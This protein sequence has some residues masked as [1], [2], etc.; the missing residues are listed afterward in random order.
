MK[1]IVLL[2]NEVMGPNEEA[3][4]LLSEELD[5]E[6]KGVVIVDENHKDDP[7]RRRS[8]LFHEVYVD[9]E[10]QS[11]IQLAIEPIKDKILLVTCRNEPNLTLL[12]KVIPNVPYI[13]TPTET[14]IAWSTSKYEM[15]KRFSISDPT[16]S[17]K[18]MNVAD[19]SSETVA[20]LSKDVGFPAIVKPAGLM[21][22]LLVQEVSD[23]KE[24]QRAL[25]DIFSY[26][27]GVH[28]KVG[29]HEKPEVVVEERLVGDLYS[30]DTYVNSEGKMWHC[31]IV[32]YVDGM[33]AGFND[34]F[35]YNRTA[36]AQ[37]PVTI[38]DEEVADELTEKG[39]RSLGLRST[40][41]H[42]EL[43][44][45]S[46]GWKIIEI[47]PRIGGYRHQMYKHAYGIEHTLNDMRVRINIDPVIPQDVKGYSAVYS[48]YPKQEGVLKK[49]EGLD[50][51]RSLV[52]HQQDTVYAKPGD[53]VLF[54]RN[55]GE[56]IVT[57]ILGADTEQQLQSDIDAMESSL[58]I[59]VD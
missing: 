42:T 7:R 9:M 28:D 5:R 59:L 43:I 27:Q 47:G 11:S 36:P 46:N 54:S 30:I 49:I 1:N 39:I 14:S 53:E 6:L 58:K 21:S 32:S 56:R 16:I 13:K 8:D 48:F 10:S 41:C 22:S 25:T 15:R 40:S 26:I 38:E 29:R 35:C 52:S 12:R 23:S 17:P 33:E 24:L 20:E 57:V 34:F 51:V 19:D 37:K 18:F 45:T 2:V 44:K 55:G 31:P 3:L 50:E 4:T